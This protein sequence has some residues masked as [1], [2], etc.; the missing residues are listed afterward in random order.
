[1]SSSYIL[2]EKITKVWSKFVLAS[3]VGVLLN[4]L[5]T[6]V[7]GIFVGQ[8]TGEAGLAGVNIAWPAITV[9]LG[10]GLM[11]GS[12]ASSMISIH[13]GQN[14]ILEAEKTLG[15]VIKFSIL[16]GFLLS[17]LGVVYSTPITNFLGTTSDTFSY[18]HDYFIVVYCIAIPYILSSVLNPIVRADGNPKLSMMMV[19]VGAIGNIILDWIFVIKLN[20]G[21]GGAALATGAGV[22]LS[23]LIGITYFL[24]KHSNIKLRFEHLKFDLTILKQ[25]VKIG[26]VSLM[27]QL[28][29]GI[30]IFIQNQIIYSY[31]TTS[32][33]AIFCVA[34]YIISL[35]SQLSI[36]ISQGMQPLIGYHFGA[37]SKKRMNQFLWLTLIVSFIIGIISVILLYYYGRPFISL[38]GITSDTLELAYSRVLI[39]CIGSPCIGIVYTMSAYY[40][41]IGQNLASNIV[42]ITRGL[43]LQV[44]FSV[45][46]PY[47]I[48]IDGIFYAQSLSDILSILIVFI[49]AI[50]IHYRKGT[51]YE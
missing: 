42:S 41:S 22:L 5:Y 25:I 51:N 30:V 23:T 7:D 19:C 47:F 34:G 11:L 40:Q 39:F 21:T 36:G 48:G 45:L 32:D 29:I 28:S 3:V 49:V 16:I 9:I 13:L 27:M 33:I 6:M 20:M 10:I 26:F 50:T 2:N 24:S 12:G 17:I 43:I 15:T 8:G 14:N 1:M 35:Y 18:T 38:F 44:C 31:G 4:T 46:L 37:N